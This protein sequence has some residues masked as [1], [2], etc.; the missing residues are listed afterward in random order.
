MSPTRARAV[1]VL[2]TVALVVGIAALIAA[3]GEP[4]T[5]PWGV[6]LWR[7][8]HMNMLGALLTTGG[9][10]GALWAARARSRNGTVLVGLWFGLLAV[11]LLMTLGSEANLT[12]GRGDTLS[13]LLAMT[14]GPLA[15]AL[16]P[17]P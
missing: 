11:L 7:L 9:A 6:R 14:I 17:E 8:V 16:T 10:A 13:M 2:G 3:A 12:G 15:L 1:G 4:L 5:Y